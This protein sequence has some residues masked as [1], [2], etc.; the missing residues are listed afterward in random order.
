MH[1]VK[2][3]LLTLNK[4]LRLYSSFPI[5]MHHPLM[6]RELDSGTPPCFAQDNWETGNELG[7]ILLHEDA[8]YEK[9]IFLWAWQGST[10]ILCFSWGQ[11]HSCLFLYGKE[12][13]SGV[14]NSKE[15]PCLPFPLTVVLWYQFSKRTQM[16]SRRT[17]LCGWHTTASVPRF[18][19]LLYWFTAHPRI[20]VAA[21]F[22]YRCS[23]S[24]YERREGGMV[25][26]KVSTSGCAYYQS[27]PMH[28][29]DTPG[30]LR[31]RFTPFQ[32]APEVWERDLALQSNPHHHQ[33]SVR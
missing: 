31:H 19:V 4:Q 27:M 21:S 3:K 32:F 5:S 26:N 6:C 24:C 12:R 22:H 7:C 9:S 1:C 33:H 23:V 13:N 11:T 28:K 8:Y 25:G 2:V 20:K 18:W 16:H 17:A 30:I 29:R 10:N 15:K 14:C